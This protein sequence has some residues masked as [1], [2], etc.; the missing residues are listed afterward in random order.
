MRYSKYKLERV[1]FSL[2][3]PIA[4]K[5]NNPSIGAVNA[6]QKKVVYLHKISKQI[7]SLLL[8]KTLMLSFAYNPAFYFN[9]GKKLQRYIS[10]SSTCFSYYRE[11]SNKNN[12][13]CLLP[14]SCY[15]H[16][17]HDWFYVI[18]VETWMNTTII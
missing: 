14:P 7:K 4:R 18:S 8:I 1:I 3:L 11:H 9:M 2:I 5:F 10:L 13:I 17:F 15:Q 6:I 16:H 12:K